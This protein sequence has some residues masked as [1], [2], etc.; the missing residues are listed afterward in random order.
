MTKGVW[1]S[2]KKVE[3]HYELTSLK[4]IS[5]EAAELGK[6]INQGWQDTLFELLTKR[7]QECSHKVLD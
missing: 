4:E 1:V 7:K 2:L 3:K 5:P 6:E